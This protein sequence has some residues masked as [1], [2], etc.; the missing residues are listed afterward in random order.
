MWARAPFGRALVNSTLV[1]TTITL[2]VLVFGSMTAYA[3]ARL[4]FRGRPALN[5]A[6]I[7]VLL[8]PGQLDTDSALHAD[9]AAGVD[10]HLC[11]AHR[12]IPVQRHSNPDAAPVLSPDP[13][14]AHRR[15]PDG[16][17]GG[18]AVLAD[19][20]HRFAVAVAAVFTSSMTTRPDVALLVSTSGDQVAVLGWRKPQDTSSL[21]GYVV[22]PSSS[23]VPLGALERGRPAPVRKS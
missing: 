13:A 8:V 17:H 20:V 14:I 16:R 9:C 1:A 12:A 10:R 7:A 18:V 15:G 21:A 2:A 6:T 3:M 22:V 4:R 5:A 19:F 23:Y 11:R